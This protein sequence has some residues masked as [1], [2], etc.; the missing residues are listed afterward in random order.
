M[1]SISNIFKKISDF[2]NDGELQNAPKLNGS[3]AEQ[4]TAKKSNPSGGSSGYSF[5]PSSKSGG[6]A[7]VFTRNTGV[8]SASV[9]DAGKSSTPGTAG[10]MFNRSTESTTPKVGGVSPAGRSTTPKLGGVSLIDQNPSTTSVRAALD[11]SIDS[12]ATKRRETSSTQSPRLAY[13]DMRGQGDTAQERANRTYYAEY[14]NYS[15]RFGEL[16]LSTDA[17]KSEYDKLV[18]ELDDRISTLRRTPVSAGNPNR[19]SD[20]GDYTDSRVDADALQWVKDDLESWGR[21]ASVTSA[22]YSNYE[23]QQ[24]ADDFI[25]TVFAGVIES[26]DYERKAQEGIE[27]AESAFGAKIFGSKT[28]NM[29][30]TQKKL[31]GYTYATQGKTAANELFEDFLKDYANY[32]EAVDNFEETISKDSKLGRGVSLFGETIATGLDQWLS[33]AKQTFKDSSVKEGNDLIGSYSVNDAAD[34]YI[35][36]QYGEILDDAEF[37]RYADLGMTYAKTSFA[38]DPWYK[39]N[40]ADASELQQKLYGYVL[41]GYGE[42][43]ARQTMEGI[44]GWK[45]SVK[46]VVQGDGA[47]ASSAQSQEGALYREYLGLSGTSAPGINAT[48]DEDT[49]VA[50]VIWDLGVTTANQIPQWAAVLAGS[51]IGGPALGRVLGAAVMSTGVYGNSYNESIK[52]GYSEKQATIYAATQA[53]MEGGVGILLDGFGKTAGVLTTKVLG[54]EALQSIANPWMKAFADL[55]I[56]AAS[57]GAE[58]YIQE[59]ADPIIRNIVLDENN[60]FN[61]MSDEAKY[62][63]ILGALSAG[64]MDMVNMRTNIKSNVM[65][66]RLGKALN[67]VGAES[68]VVDTILNNPVEADDALGITKEQAKLYSEAKSMAEGIKSGTIKATG[69]NIGKMTQLYGAAGGDLSFLTNPS[70]VSY[71]KDTLTSGDLEAGAKARLVQLNADTKT[72]GVIVKL[73]MGEQLSTEEQA[74]YDAEPQ[75]KTV[76]TELQGELDLS[77]SQNALSMAAAASTLQSAS[78]KAYQAIV[79]NNSDKAVT[80]PTSQAMMQMGMKYSVATQ[81]SSV[82]NKVLDGQS[83]T[84]K[85]AGAVIVKSPIVRKVVADRLGIELS[86]SSTAADV[87]SAFNSKAAEMATIAA[88]QKD[89]KRTAKTTVKAQQQ[90]AAEKAA[91][92]FRRNDNGSNARGTDGSVR[93]YAESGSRGDVQAPASVRGSEGAAGVAERAAASGVRL[94]RGDAGV[95]Q[96][97]PADTSLRPEQIIP[98]EDLTDEQRSTKR[99]LAEKGFGNII[100]F[101]KGDNGYAGRTFFSSET[102]TYDAEICAN[103]QFTADQYGEHETIHLW[104]KSISNNADTVDRIVKQI[105][106]DDYARIG[107]QYWAAYSD[108]Y[109]TL[110]DKAFTRAVKEEMLCDA[111]AGMSKYGYDYTEFQAKAR[112][113]VES[114]GIMAAG[115]GDVSNPKVQEYAQNGEL[116]ATFYERMGYSLEADDS[117]FAIDE[118]VEKRTSKLIEV[119]ENDKAKNAPWNQNGDGKTANVR[120]FLERYGV[121]R[122]EMRWLQLDKALEGKD[123]INRYE[124]IDLM[125][126]NM[127]EIQVRELSGEDLRQSGHTLPG[128]ENQRE[129]LFILPGSGYT[130]DAM[131]THWEN[132]AK[133]VLAHARVDDRTI[134]EDRTLYIDEI[135]SDWHNE[136]GKTGYLSDDKEAL[137]K[138]QLKHYT[139]ELSRV[140]EHQHHEKLEIDLDSLETVTEQTM[141]K[142]TEVYTKQG[143]SI[144]LA[145]ADPT[146]ALARKVDNIESKGPYRAKTPDAPFETNYAEFVMKSLIKRAI[147]DGYDM[148]AWSSAAIQSER[149]SVDYQSAYENM[150]NKQLVGFM[151]KFGKQFGIP[152]EMKNIDVTPGTVSRNKVTE[153]TPASKE[154]PIWTFK[155]NEQI[156]DSLEGKEFSLFAVDENDGADAQAVHESHRADFRLDPGADYSEYFYSPLVRFINSRP[157]NAKTGRIAVGNADQFVKAALNAG[158]KQDEVTF[159]GLRDFLTGRRDFSPEEFSEWYWNSQAAL[160]TWRRE[161]ADAPWSGFTYYGGSDYHTIE[162][163]LP[164]YRGYVTPDLSTHFEGD[165]DVAAHARISRQS[166]RNGEAVVHI[167]EAQSDLANAGHKGGET[168]DAPL[169]K[170]YPERIIK[171]AIAEALE[172]NIDYVTWTPAIAQSVRWSFDYNGAYRNTYDTAMRNA[173]KKFGTVSEERLGNYYGEYDSDFYR[174]IVMEASIR[175]GINQ[176]KMNEL[177]GATEDEFFRRAAALTRMSEERLR[178][179]GIDEVYDTIVDYQ[180]ESYRE[181]EDM[182][183]LTT[184]QERVYNELQA[185]EALYYSDADIESADVSGIDPVALNKLRNPF[186]FEWTR[187]DAVE[188]LRAV[189]NGYTDGDIPRSATSTDTKGDH[190]VDILNYYADALESNGD[191]VWV[192]TIDKDKVAD[193]MSLYAID[194]DIETLMGVDEESI[195]ARNAK[196]AIAYEEGFSTDDATL[197]EDIYWDA[198]LDKLDGM[199]AGEKAAVWSNYLAYQ[200]RSTNKIK[201]DKRTKEYREGAAETEANETIAADESPD[202]DFDLGDKRVFDEN[203]EL[204][205]EAYNRAWEAYEKRSAHDETK[206]GKSKFPIRKA[207]EK[208]GGEDKPVTEKPAKQKPKADPFKPKAETEP[209]KTEVPAP[210]PRADVFKAKGEPAAAKAAP[211]A[212]AAAEA[213]AAT[214]TAE[215]PALTVKT[216]KK[217]GRWAEGL[218]KTKSGAINRRA[219]SRNTF[220]IMLL[221]PDGT[222]TRYDDIS[223]SMLQRIFGKQKADEITALANQNIG[224]DTWNFFSNEKE[225]PKTEE[226]VE[227]P[228]EKDTY[229]RKVAPKL[230]E[231]MKD[232]K[233]REGETGALIPVYRLAPAAGVRNAKIPGKA[234]W[235]TDKPAVANTH[236]GLSGAAAYGQEGKRIGSRIAAINSQLE[237]ATGDRARA[238]RTELART[239]RRMREYTNGVTRL[240]PYREA[241][242]KAKD[243]DIING[244]ALLEGYVNITKPLTIDAKGKGADFVEAETRKVMSDPELKAKYD[245][246]IFKNANMVAEGATLGG[247]NLDASNVYVTFENKQGKSTYNTAPTDSALMQYALDE[248]FDTGYTEG[249]I[250]DLVLKML[251]DK[252]ENHALAALTEYF[253]QLMQEQE[254]PEV[255]DAVRMRRVFQPRVTDGE[256]ILIRN[257][258]DSLIQQYGAIPEGEKAARDV[259]LPNQTGDGVKVRRFLRTA[260]EAEQTP[261][262]AVDHITRMTLTD[263]GASYA[264]ISDK[265]ALSYADRQFRKKGYD[266]VLSEWDAHSDY[267]YMPKKQDIALGEMLFKEAAKVGDYDTAMRVLADVAEMGTKAGQVVQAMS[268]L[269]KMTPQGQLYYFQRTVDRLNTD[270][271]KR[272]ESGRMEQLIINRD[273]AKRVLE[274]S[275]QEELAAAMDALIQDIADQIPATFT[276]KWNAWRYLAMLGNPRTHIRNIVGNAVFAPAKFAKDLMA[277]GLE[278]AFIPDMSQRTKSVSGVLGIGAKQYRDFATTDFEL[279]KDELTGG[280]KYN[281]SDEVRERRTIF[282]LRPLEYLRKKNGEW[283]ETED[284]WFLKSHYVNALTSYLAAQNADIVELQTTR[285]GARVLNAA[286]EYAIGEAQKATYRDYSALAAGLNKIKRIPGAGILAEGLVPFTKTPLNVLKRGMEYSPLGLMKTISYDQYRLRNGDI[287]ANQFIDNLAAGMTGSMITLLGVFLASHDILRGSGDDDDNQQEFDE[288]QGY[289]DYSINVGNVNYTIDWMAPVAMPLFVGAELWKNL[290]DGKLSFGDIVHLATTVIEPMTSLSMLDGLNSALKSARYDDYPLASIAVTMGS[291]YVSQAVPTLLGQISRSMVS[292]RRTTYID[293]NS[294]MPSSFQRWWQTNVVGKTPLNAGRTAYVDAWGRKDT[295][296]NFVVRLFQNMLSPGYSNRIQTTQLDAELQR[297]ADSVGTSVLMTSPETDF[298]FE[299]TKYNLSAEQYEELATV[300]GQVAYGMLTDL[301]NDM[302]Y[303]ELSDTAKAKAIANLVSYATYSARRSIMPEYDT[304]QNTWI[305]KCDG[306]ESRVMYMAMMKALASEMDITASNNSDFYSLILNT[307]WLGTTDQSYMLA[308]TWYLSGSYL[309]DSQHRGYQFLLDKEQREEVNYIYRTI[310]PN[311]FVEMANT[312]EWWYAETMDEKLALLKQ[313]R[314]ASAAAAREIAQM[315]LRDAGVQ[316]VPKQ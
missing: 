217:V 304:D 258:L 235:W 267:E 46:D 30:E 90:T 205:D 83:I 266:R 85:E 226:R 120:K 167:E 306:D 238:L 230:A 300:R 76:L 52:E 231:Y 237:G 186:I 75:A 184:E 18:K 270:N 63:F 309:T 269:K 141:A 310:F 115:M 129:L 287:T 233:A 84:A 136:G 227:T 297:L 263:E 19:L 280:G 252:D 256:R 212:K 88:Q 192:L 216:A 171:Q 197:D 35:R 223:P 23:L 201:P 274:A 173:A 9:K 107:R 161:G 99:S 78:D 232:S 22:K 16:D 110:D 116:N 261:E 111:Y 105:F 97:A 211:A 254:A 71:N 128:G 58:E 6:D 130:N 117:V 147:D 193:G 276:D 164:Q 222:Q 39:E 152:V 299:G 126:A 308:Q 104:L 247:G 122:E 278:G 109:P 268:L 32:D 154:Y 132:T 73:A 34:S 220:N 42:D 135:Q 224:E 148:L 286:R 5:V 302:G 199:S 265:S 11:R 288:L 178:E 170:G 53:A 3:L 153:Q 45:Q 100:F 119:L 93:G 242:T 157:K 95:L 203:A 27:K 125:R 49:T 314:D 121:S 149:W 248:D 80:N 56:R 113:L 89:L 17:G 260:A 245:G 264:P 15:K 262:H 102:Q 292:D 236:R 241:F 106:A 259:R 251:H 181:I 218:A 67:T 166:N 289:Q 273:L 160:E 159:S 204:S 200:E 92:I 311:Y 145:F 281:P 225:Q 175:V 221:N 291:S 214:E 64:L 131:D 255:D 81:Q 206:P 2:F 172:N 38:G 257:Q 48:S 50:Q 101:R 162:L 294:D 272:I 108:K 176:F 315:R 301:I 74:V 151:G 65:A 1:A 195:E 213:P 207:E 112:E 187:E 12:L 305:E 51:Y 298:S 10:F 29:T 69:I 20:T 183:P 127:L 144:Y 303:A 7:S 194:E 124:L 210:K 277:A 316:S 138:K 189:A 283:L 198:L 307:P 140:F 57:E 103:G 312:D 158:I 77:N 55:G 37:Q 47:L 243:S 4:N 168:F 188:T 215:A 228:R 165:R 219:L 191:P 240:D 14:G 143:K 169:R 24:K 94:G 150:Y 246:I 33:G 179:L 180:L 142:L 190:T 61:L 28:D 293:K 295:T 41:A 196:E 13:Q 123:R 31:Y 54:T 66:E 285:D 139:D 271:L 155:L 72:A 146:L 185:L 275:S 244:M 290:S 182:M 313:V 96:G 177:R 43:T 26:P 21:K 36:Q 250:E 79:A 282:K 8:S 59:I 279:V 82:I 86:E 118:S 296:D 249:T 174:D 98:A 202:V 40:V 134:G 156:K 62:S 133:E 60:E 68:K 229:G 163:V 253:S 44:N 209:I 91:T 234:T 25:N 284:A 70:T 87:M 114:E 239:E 137:E 208:P